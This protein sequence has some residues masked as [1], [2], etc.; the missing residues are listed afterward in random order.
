MS[1]F[2]RSGYKIPG[3]APHELT[4]RASYDHDNGDLR[5]LGAFVEYVYK[6]SYFI[7]NGNQ[8]TIPSYGLVNVN[9]HYE[10]GEIDGFTK[11]AVLFFEVRN[12]LDSSYVASA[13]VISN[14][15]NAAGYQNPGA[16]LAQNST[17][18]YAG[19]PRAVQGG[20]KFSF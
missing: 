7:D 14:S 4:A 6:S 5:G 19:A 1:R 16:Y 8:L 15:V 10:T 11:N 17:G 18:I 13:T 3:V 9:V 20:V 12:L 2:D